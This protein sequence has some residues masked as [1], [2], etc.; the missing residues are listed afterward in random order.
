MNRNTPVWWPIQSPGLNPFHFYKWGFLLAKVFD[1]RP[2]RLIRESISY[3]ATS[4][5]PETVVE[6][7]EN[8][9][10]RVNLNYQMA[11]QHFQQNIWKIQKF[12]VLCIYC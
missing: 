5:V 3:F 11:G 12:Q 10:K 7:F 1:R 2:Q 4:I 9:G 6:V 8:F